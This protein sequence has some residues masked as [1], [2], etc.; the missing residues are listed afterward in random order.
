MKITR[1]YATPD[2][3]SHFGEVEIPLRDAGT[4]GKL[5]DPLEAGGETAAVGPKLLF[6]DDSLQHAGLFFGRDLKGQWLNQHYFKGLPRDFAPANVA[7]SVPGVTGA[8][9]LI[10][11]AV[12]ERLG[13]FTEDYIIGDYED[14][15]LCLKIRNA[16]H[17]I[18]YVPAA[19]LYHLERKSIER[20]A[21]YMRGVVSQYNQWLH[22]GRW[23]GLMQ[24]IMS[25]AIGAAAGT[26]AAAALVTA[27]AAR[28][29]AAE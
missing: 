9:M 28:A 20:H 16:G 7:R 27:P 1:V 23:D 10:R 19:E 15:D 17:D 21:G 6:E 12:Y 29:E 3:E 4:I 26:S 13:G 8:A 5:S 2:G 18:H 22:A 14:S 11:R 25:G 24:E